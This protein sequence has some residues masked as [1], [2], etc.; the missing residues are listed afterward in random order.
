M[1]VLRGLKFLMSEVPLYQERLWSVN[2]RG[3]YIF[4]SRIEGN[5]LYK[6]F[7][8]VLYKTFSFPETIKHVSSAAILGVQG[9]HNLGRQVGSSCADGLFRPFACA[10]MHVT[11]PHNHS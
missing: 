5:V 4:R 2:G 10:R 9:A 6:T 3:G 8:N 1:V 11:S 7:P